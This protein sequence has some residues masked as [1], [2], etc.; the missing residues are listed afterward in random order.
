VPTG[1]AAR[2]PHC[3]LPGA[4]V[5]WITGAEVQK[6]KAEFQA[7]RDYQGTWSLHQIDRRPPP[8]QSLQAGFSPA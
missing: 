5:G 1:Q 7:R 3:R 2:T 8:A 6:L 4:I